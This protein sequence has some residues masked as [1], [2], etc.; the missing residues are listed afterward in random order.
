MVKAI[1][2]GSGI[3]GLATAIR[4]AR[5]GIDVQVYEATE[6]PGGKISERKFDGFRFDTGPSLL[7]LPSLVLDLLD[8]DLRLPIKKLDIITRYFYEDGLRLDAYSDGIKMAKEMGDKFHVPQ[9]RVT[10]YLEKAATVYDLT[11]DLF[12][13]G[14]FHRLK[15][16]ARLKSIKT[17]LNFRKLK[18]FDSLHDFNKQELKEKR[19]VQ[20][21]DRYATYNG[22]NPYQSP[23]TLSVISHLEHNLGAF[24]PKEGMSS[25]I[26]AMVQQA[27]RLGI[28]FHYRQPVRKVECEEG[29]VKGV[30]VNKG[31]I[32]C[33]IIVSNVDIH[34]FYSFLL[35]DCGRFKKITRQERSS[36]ALVFFWGM[37]GTSPDLDIHNI[38]FSSSYKEEFDHLFHKKQVF[39]DPTVYVYIS[40]KYR[41]EDAP[42]GCENWFVMIN[43]PAHTGQHWKEII[44]QTRVQILQKLERMLGRNLKDEILKEEVLSPPEIESR[45]GSVNGSIYG[46]SSNSRYS[47]FNRHANFRS[48]IS[49]L[50]FVGGSVHP[51]GGIPLCL[52]SASIVDGLVKEQLGRKS[53]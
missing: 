22:S 49:G 9:E 41:K 26:G 50:Y 47:S 10:G 1:I 20:L 53:R 45:T 24:I 32:P 18:A 6:R 34:R 23:A 17:L 13:F 5:Q 43:A 27:A 15:S 4:L 44:E 35:P 16:L 37:R 29:K 2:I 36:S 11:A 42:E 14:S 19:L 40:S 12:I 30:W 51:G 46:S 52:S 48:D 25:I 38:F 3:G 28:K 31:F 33:D 39:D 7:T 8:E 21:F